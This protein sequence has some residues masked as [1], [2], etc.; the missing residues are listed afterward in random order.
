LEADNLRQVLNNK[1]GVRK[2]QK[3][4]VDFNVQSVFDSEKLEEV[5]SR[6]IEKKIQSETK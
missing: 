6:A 3:I 2:R 5:L 4:S 1:G